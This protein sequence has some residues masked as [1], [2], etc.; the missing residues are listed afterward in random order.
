MKKN[1]HLYYL[2]IFSY[3][4]AVAGCQQPVSES[5]NKQIDYGKL[6]PDAPK[7]TIQLGQLVGEW[8]CLSKDLVTI[9]PDSSVWYENDATWTWEYTLGGHALI[10]H[11]WQEDN[12]PTART[13]EYFAAGI[14]IVNPETHLWEAVV[15]NSRP[16]KLS[17]KF[18]MEY[19]D[20]TLQMH[21]GTGQWL[22]TFYDIGEQSFEWKYELI[23]EQGHRKT[24]SRISAQRTSSFTSDNSRAID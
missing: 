18:E 4:L 14:F 2:L 3:I 17:P 10:N 11:W 9:K 22:V 12:S 19:I 21:D 7:E 16:H 1:A 6:N 24:I 5:V 15:M 8:Q 23:D 13:A 20:Q